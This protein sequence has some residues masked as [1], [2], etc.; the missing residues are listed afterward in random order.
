MN[1]RTTY[2]SR[3]IVV[4]I[5][6]CLYAL[7]GIF[8]VLRLTTPS[9]GTRL[10]LRTQNAP[11]DA[12]NLILLADQP[13]GLQPDDHVI[14]IAGRS[15]TE[16]AAAIFSRDSLAPQWRFN[17]TIIYTVRRDGQTLDVPVQVGHFPIGI[18]LRD[19]LAIVLL[20]IVLQEE[21]AWI[22]AS[23]PDARV[24]Q[25][26]FVAACA[27]STFSVCYFLGM[28]VAG[29]VNARGLWLY[30]RLLTFVMMM[31]IG[32]TL[33]HFALILPRVYGEYRLDKRLTRFIYF[34]PYPLYALY[35]ALTY[36]SQTLE[37]LRQWEI[38]ALLLLCG[39]FIW[40][41]FAIVGSYR[42]L[43]DPAQ[44]KRVEL[45]VV[46]FILSIFLT[47]I[48]GWIPSWLM[49]QPWSGW[50]M[51]PLFALPIALGLAAAI[52][53]YRL[54]D[55]RVVIQRT[56][57]WGALTTMVVAVYVAV[58]GTLSVLSQTQGNPLFALI[59]TGLAAM[60]FQPL[61]ERLQHGVTTLL[62]GEVDTPYEV[63]ARLSKKL[64]AALAPQD[65]LHTIV[66]TI[67]DSLK[68]SYTAIELCQDGQYITTAECGTPEAVSAN[69][70]IEFPLV[71]GSDTVGRLMVAPRMSG[72]SLTARDR[73]LIEGLLHH[74]EVTI[75][76]AQL[77]A[78]LQRSREKL[79]AAREEERRRLRR[80]LHDGLGPALASLTLQL[81]A[82]RNLLKH[83]TPKADTMLVELKGQVQAALAEV[84]RIAYELRPPALDELGLL[85][86][87]DQKARQFGQ[88]GELTVTIDAPCLPPLPAA[89]EGAAYRI[90]MEA[91]TNAARHAQATTCAI[92]LTVNGRLGIEIHDNGKGL[93]PDFR[94]GVGISSMMERADELGGMCAVEND[95]A[96]GTCVRAFLPL[97][98]PLAVPDERRQPL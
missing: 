45:L 57:I 32:S 51:I 37:W 67:N 17:D 44:R 22:F 60:L 71:Y 91:L 48:V 18:L 21:A 53:F 3:S 65:A 62:Y 92:R 50:N 55:I 80:D 89:V 76:T 78:D 49:R 74:A 34:A 8:V 31:I 85:A 61:R 96:G 72:E 54:L 1:T 93:P 42:K 47:L 41:M 19:N 15:I 56:L 7:A 5:A 40:A 70:W 29:F 77:T 79:V 46:A 27:M 24:T 81:D 63:V 30:Y 6:T 68:V 83:N 87:L 26:I 52:V 28:D 66:Q 25:T 13:G 94:R 58:V 98:V 39:L 38:G 10:A 9:D 90:V 33:L 97:T 88:S 75:L 59:A 23:R 69:Q 43:T 64:E 20:V 11:P 73:R 14:R 36:Q 4:I 95:P 12:I 2:R 84:R 35:L 16:W 82:A 86:A